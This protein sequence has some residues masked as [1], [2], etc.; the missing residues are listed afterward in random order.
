[1]SEN[2]EHTVDRSRWSAGPW[3]GEADRD[4]WRAH[5]FPC[6]IVRSPSTGA[7]CGY[8]GLPPGHALHGKSYGDDAVDALDV[9]GG[10]TYGSA[11]AGHICHVPRDGEPAEVWWLGF[12]C[13]HGGDDTPI[14]FPSSHLMLLGFGFG[15]DDTSERGAEDYRDMAYVRAETEKLAEQLARAS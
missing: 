14:A 3:D 4:E 2:T 13:S 6:L 11:C 8:V 1:M 15:L 10:I 12:D 9:H 7:L 5:G